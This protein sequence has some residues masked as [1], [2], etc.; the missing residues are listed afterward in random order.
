MI[1]SSW[2][3]HANDAAFFI[4]FILFKPYYRIVRQAAYHR[5]VNP[6]ASALASERAATERQTGVDMLGKPL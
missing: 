5:L 6:P 4:V 2:P 1:L 3:P